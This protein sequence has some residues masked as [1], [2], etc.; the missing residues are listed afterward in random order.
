[1]AGTL[2]K[3]RRRK[4]PSKPYP[5]FPLTAHNNGQWCKKIHGKIF[6]FGVWA[7]PQEA[8]QN[9]LRA[10]ADLQAGRQPRSETITPE[11]I[12]VKDACNHFLTYQLQKLETGEIGARWF[13]DCRSTAEHFARFLGPT[14]TVRDLTPDDFRQ[15]RQKLTRNGLGQKGTGLGVY[16]LSR[17]M[18]VI[19]SIFKYA[20]EIDII[21]APVKFGRAFE[22]P[23]V[24]LTRKTRRASELANGRRLFKAAEIRS[25]IEAAKIPLRAMIFL[26]INGGFGNTDCARLPISAVDFNQALIDFHRP[27]T[28]IERVVPL[29]PE[30]LEALRSSLAARPTPVSDVADRLLFLTTFGRPWVR[31][32]VRQDGDRGPAKV[33][34]QDAISQEF[35]KL[36]KSLGLKRK[37]VGFY[38]LRH[39]FRT[40]ADEVRDQHAIHR[41]MGHIIPGMSGAYIE[42]IE[43]HRLRN[44]V[45]CV[46][47]KLFADDA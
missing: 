20:Y 36:L 42:T 14:R 23:S 27:K 28:G 32:E 34:V 24:V 41:I 39:T 18:S 19:K 45:S 35:T 40:W 2:K 8:L 44:V 11:G 25:M 21:N 1:M 30:T 12:T 4:K 17:S 16:A 15:Y 33:A 7:D 47:R 9:Y 13:Q 46:R 22:K 29:W 26:G 5:S 38:S 37:G 10:A 31:E 6:F 43:Q 3:T